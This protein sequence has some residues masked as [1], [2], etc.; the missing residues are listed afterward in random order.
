MAVPVQMIR[1]GVIGVAIASFVTF[2]YVAAGMVED[3]I[4]MAMTK[5]GLSSDTLSYDASVDLFGFNTHL[6]DITIN[7]PGQ[8]PIEID[9]VIINDFDTNHDIPE[10]MDIE[11]EGIKAKKMLSSPLLANASQGIF[12]EMETVN[13][14]F[15]IKYMF[16]S[17][18]KILDIKEISESV[19]G[20]GKI[21]FSTVLH[22]IA[23]MKALPQ[24]VMM[25]PKSILIGKSELAYE[26]DSLVEKLMLINAK[27]ENISVAEYKG[28]MLVELNKELV[29][30]K[31]EEKSDLKKDFLSTI[32]S[33][34]KS[35]D[36]LEISINPQTPMNLQ[37]MTKTN[38]EKLIKKLNLEIN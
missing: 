9:E 17:D 18:D 20:L 11:I 1:L 14:N 34:I 13:T 29:K 25:N 31:K 4:G 28:K 12:N 21:S 5:S 8:A 2:K 22:N 7:L 30:A 24:I 32:I 6:H 35:P 37:A 38:P 33:F 10:Y 3:K 23:S 19:D 26:D 15:A 16:D 27:K 36:T